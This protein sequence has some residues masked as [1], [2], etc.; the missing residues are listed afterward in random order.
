MLE[1]PLRILLTDPHLRGGGQVTYVTRLAAELTRLGHDVTIGCK[2]ESVLVEHASQA[3]C[4]VHNRFLYRGGM[5]PRC[6]WRDLREVRR[7]IRTHGPDIIHVSGSQDH[8]VGAIGNR[9]LGRPVCLVRTRHNTYA[10]KNSLPN[11]ILNRA[12]T[13]YQ[14]VVCEEVR[15]TLA[16]H[17]AFDE[18]RMCSIHNGVDPEEYQPD[19]EVRRKAREEFG[20]TDDHIVCGIAARLVADKGHAFLFQAAARIVENYPNMRILVLGEGDEETQLR[21]MA[22]ELKITSIVHFAGFRS[23]MAYC[24]RA[25]DIAVLPS[26]GCETSSFSLKEEMAAGKPVVASDYGGLKEIVADG[27]EGLVVPAGSIEPLAAALR[28]L[29]EDPVAR[30]R[31]GEAARS[32]VLREFSLEVFAQRTLAAYRRAMEIHRVRSRRQR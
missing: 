15:Q 5:R 32:R 18:T 16:R 14:I 30:K 9:L 19:P 1:R 26:I 20:Y 17:P 28:R 10:V 6:W 4:G 24:T 29:L 8:W 12:W 27:V 22:A 3:G 25:F 31:M 21:Q 7:Y 11:R 2:V 13:D 23:D